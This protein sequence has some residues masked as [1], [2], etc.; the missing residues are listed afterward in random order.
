MYV[1]AL[2]CG[3]ARPQPDQIADL[4]GATI[5]KALL[6]RAMVEQWWM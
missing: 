6:D 1:A 3:V 4:A 2:A 5:D